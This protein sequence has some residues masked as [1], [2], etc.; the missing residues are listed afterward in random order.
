MNIQE[1]AKRNQLVLKSL[2]EPGATLR[3]VGKQFG[4]TH[5]AVRHIRNTTILKEDEDAE[6]NMEQNLE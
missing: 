4:L 1:K 6:Q 5:G 3:S 2:N